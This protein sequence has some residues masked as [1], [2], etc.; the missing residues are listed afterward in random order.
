VRGVRVRGARGGA[1][2]HGPAVPRLLLHPEGRPVHRHAIPRVSPPLSVSPQLSW[3]LHYYLHLP[4]LLT[5]WQY[6]CSRVSNPSIVI[7]VL[8]RRYVAELLVPAHLSLMRIYGCLAILE[9]ILEAVLLFSVTGIITS[10]F[11]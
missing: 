11:G 3:M 6:A 1:S 9:Q 4:Y 7:F 5:F 2:L 8:N 10:D